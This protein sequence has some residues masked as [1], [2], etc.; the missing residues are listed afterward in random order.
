MVDTE[1]E[2]EFVPD[3]IVFQVDNSTALRAEPIS[4][5]EAGLRERHSKGPGP[6]DD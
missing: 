6:V 2:Q 5:E 4:L 3:E 1:T